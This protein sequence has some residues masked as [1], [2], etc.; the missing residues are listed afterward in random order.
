M[1]VL[2]RQTLFEAAAGDLLSSGAIAIGLGMVTTAIALYIPARRSLGREVIGERGEMAMT[3]APAWRRLR[4][5]LVLLA[6]AAVA[7]LI[8]LRSGAFDAQSASVSAGA[9]V[10]LPSRMLVA[11]LVAWIGG[12]LLSVR[13]FEGAASR[14]PVPARPRSFSLADRSATLK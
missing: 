5:D 8:A 1:A 9:S 12:V 14:L 4:L 10:S 6:V 2:G 13:L 7:E 11:P 3:P